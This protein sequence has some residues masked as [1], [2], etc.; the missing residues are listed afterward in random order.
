MAV[1]GHR[2]DGDRRS[3]RARPFSR[4]RS[5]T[6][7]GGDPPHERIAAGGRRQISTRHSPS[8]GAISATAIASASP[9]ASSTS[10]TA[11]R[12]P[13]PRSTACLRT[14]SSFRI[15]WS[16]SFQ[17]SSA[18]RPTSSRGAAARAKRRASRRTAPSRKAGCSSRRSISA[19]S[20]HAI[21]KFERAITIDPRYA[22]AYTGLASAQLAAYEETPVGECAGAGPAER[23]PSATRGE[24]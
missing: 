20:A 12:W 11:R 2:R 24:P 13:T 17:R 16:R 4:R 15:A 8:S 19:K 23:P 18:L 21:A 1:C 6:G 22:L 9:P 10:R 14:S 5:R 7:H 3:A